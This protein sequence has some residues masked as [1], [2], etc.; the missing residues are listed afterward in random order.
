MANKDEGE[1]APT[2]VVLLVCV[3]CGREVQLESGDSP[4]AD[5][6]CE[7]CGNQVFRRFD[8]AAVPDEVQA[9]YREATERDLDTDDTAT[10]TERGDLLDLNNP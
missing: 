9:D 8:D 10:D 3:E 5:L 1:R 2:E 4:P 7:K 6:T